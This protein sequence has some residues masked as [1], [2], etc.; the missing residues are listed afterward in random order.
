[1]EVDG[2]SL[3]FGENVSTFFASESFEIPFR[4]SATLLARV[5]RASTFLMESMILSR[6]SFSFL[7]RK[8]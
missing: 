5:I 2:K 6:S 1:M 4:D 8:A 7:L 3:E